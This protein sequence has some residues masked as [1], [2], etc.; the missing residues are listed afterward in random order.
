MDDIFL[1]RNWCFICWL[2][3]FNNFKFAK[4]FWQGSFHISFHWIF[5]FIALVLVKQGLHYWN[6]NFIMLVNDCEEKQ[7]NLSPEQRVYFVFA[8]K[9]TQNNYL[10]P[11]SG[12]NI[13]TSKIAILFSFVIAITAFPSVIFWDIYSG[14][15]LAIPVPRACAD[16]AISSVMIDAYFISAG[17]ATRTTIFDCSNLQKI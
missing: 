9:K 12:A 4:E 8:N 11:I 15:R 5:D 14:E 17:I 2:L 3:Y 6:I 1:C 7:L 13:S 10:S 16:E